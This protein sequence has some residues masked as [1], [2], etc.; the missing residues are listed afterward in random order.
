MSV[1]LV[2]VRK[3][4]RLVQVK[5]EEEEVVVPMVVTVLE[6]IRTK[7]LLLLPILIFL[8]RRLQ[9]RPQR[10]PQRRLSQTTTVQNNPNNPIQIMQEK[11]NDFRDGKIH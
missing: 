9:R 3:D 2:K 11:K 6:M 10:R 7:P 5:D 8:H 4:L 1:V